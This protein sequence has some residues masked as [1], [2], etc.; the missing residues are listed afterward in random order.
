MTPLSGQWLT[1]LVL[2][3]KPYLF[4]AFSHPWCFFHIPHYFELVAVDPPAKFDFFLGVG[5]SGKPNLNSTNQRSNPTAVKE[6]EG[7]KPQRVALALVVSKPGFN[8]DPDLSD[9]IAVVPSRRRKRLGR[10]KLV[11]FFP[12]FD[13]LSTMAKEYQ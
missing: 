10:D 7:R 11:P 8:L 9:L 12:L 5:V 4:P 1:L 2:G 6:G 13:V 3:H